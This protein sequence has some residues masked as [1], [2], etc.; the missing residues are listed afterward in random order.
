MSFVSRGVGG[1]VSL[2][3]S[4]KVK[5]TVVTRKRAGRIRPVGVGRLLR[6]RGHHLL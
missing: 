6:C 3:T 5:Q 2:P 4:R 1:D